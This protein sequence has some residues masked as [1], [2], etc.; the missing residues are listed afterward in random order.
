MRKSSKLS[1]VLHVLLHMADQAQPITS[2][3]L[4]IMMSSN[5]V[6]VRRTLSGLRKRGLVTSSKGRTGGWTLTCDLSKITLLE[7]YEAVGKPAIFAVG[8]RNEATG[9]L[10]EKAVNAALDDSLLKAE[11]LLMD[12]FASI[13][14]QSLYQE[15]SRD[16]AEVRRVFSEKESSISV[17]QKR[18]HDDG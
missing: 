5:A 4:A 15:F 8:S 14:L 11:S 17:R 1:D 6:V 16:M 12:S 2:E 18:K 9:C 13:T 3:S 7:I 10:V